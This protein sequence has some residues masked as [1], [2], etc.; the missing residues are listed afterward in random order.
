MP[1]LNKNLKCATF[2]HLFTHCISTVCRA[3]WKI[4]TKTFQS[5]YFLLLIL[6]AAHARAGA[7]LVQPHPLGS[8]CILVYVPSAKA[9]LVLL[10][11]SPWC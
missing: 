9:S 6:I 8:V 11:D 3:L 7:E 10:L 1:K 5:G 4:Y 2:E